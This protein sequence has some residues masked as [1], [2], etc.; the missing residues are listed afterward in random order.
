LAREKE[1]EAHRQAEGGQA[2]NAEQVGMCLL[3]MVA[4]CFAVFLLAAAADV[5]VSAYEKWK[6]VRHYWNG[7]K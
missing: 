3:G 1:S 7:R 5:A 6:N 4:A 2:V